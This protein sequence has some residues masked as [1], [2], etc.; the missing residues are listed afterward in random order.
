MTPKLFHKLVCLLKGHKAVAQ[1]KLHRKRRAG[2]HRG[3]CLR[4]RKVLWMTYEES[5]Q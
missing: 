4:C 1:T 2:M 5:A 3:Y